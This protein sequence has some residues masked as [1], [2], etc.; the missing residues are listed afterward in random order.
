VCSTLPE[1]CLRGVAP[2]VTGAAFF[3]GRSRRFQ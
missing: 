1:H 3:R 2:E